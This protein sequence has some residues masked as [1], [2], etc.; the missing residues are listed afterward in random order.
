MARVIGYIVQ[1]KI[2]GDP[3]WWEGAYL[4]TDREDAHL[5][6]YKEG[7]EQIAR[8]MVKYST[9]RAVPVESKGE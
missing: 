5:F 4:T 6:R 8:T 9:A 3:F 7:A 2:H 1:C